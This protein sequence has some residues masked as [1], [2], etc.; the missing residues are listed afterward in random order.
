M[1]TA[2]RLAATL[3]TCLGLCACSTPRPAYI[4]PGPDVPTANLRIITN[5]IVLG[6]EYT[7]CISEGKVLARITVRGSPNTPTPPRIEKMPPRIAPKLK[8]IGLAIHPF[9]RRYDEALSEQRVPAGVPF[10]IEMIGAFD[11]VGGNSGYVCPGV[12]RVF[13]FEKNKNY[14]AYMGINATNISDKK[15]VMTCHYT[16]VEL[17]PTSKKQLLQSKVV[18]GI[19]VAPTPCK[20]QEK[21]QQPD[22]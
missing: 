21:P 1:N 2:L 18:P 5:T 19:G 17:L 10:L 6:Q 8:D 4:S 12:R 3:F 14:E 16:L 15:Y 20:K 13:F 11:G 22:S 7:G 9:S